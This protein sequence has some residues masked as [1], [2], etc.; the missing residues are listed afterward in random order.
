[1]KMLWRM[2]FSILALAPIWH[3][4]TL[5]SLSVGATVCLAYLVGNLAYVWWPLKKAAVR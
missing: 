1:M 4:A 5:G 3:W 2:G